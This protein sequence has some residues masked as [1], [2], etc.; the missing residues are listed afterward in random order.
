MRYEVADGEG[1]VMF[2]YAGRVVAARGP[3]WSFDV[4]HDYDFV[5]VGSI[6]RILASVRSDITIELHGVQ[7]VVVDDEG[8]HWDEPFVVERLPAPRL[9]G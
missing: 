6:E 5:P 9:P 7:L 3:L 2:R 1:V 8:P 4:R